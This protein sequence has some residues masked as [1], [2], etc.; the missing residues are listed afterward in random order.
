VG[1][2]DAR[3]NPVDH[4]IPE[5][6]AELATAR[7]LSSLAH[8]LLELTIADIEGATNAPVTALRG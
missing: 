5:I 2:G 1:I 8:E 3:L 6:G 7:A 4:D